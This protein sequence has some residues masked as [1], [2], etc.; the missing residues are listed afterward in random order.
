MSTCFG[1][2]LSRPRGPH[3]HSYIGEIFLL[4]GGKRKRVRGF[5]CSNVKIKLCF[6]IIPN[7]AKML[8]KRRAFCIRT[9]SIHKAM[10]MVHKIMQ[11]LFL[12]QPTNAHTHT[13]THRQTHTHRHTHIHTHT[14]I[15]RV[16][17]YIIHT[18]TCFD[19]SVP[20]SGSF[21]F[22]LSCINS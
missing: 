20:S 19:I 2:T 4:V 21:T 6:H 11:S 17:L 18:P 3:Q 10:K 12:F 13:H 22:V 7:P 14:Y 16:Y 5:E 9:R 1:M 8:R 15:S